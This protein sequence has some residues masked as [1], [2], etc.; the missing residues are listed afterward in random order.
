MQNAVNPELR[1]YLALEPSARGRE[2]VAL[3]SATLEY[4]L[5]LHL[6]G[7]G[8]S[9]LGRVSLCAGRA[10]APRVGGEGGSVGLRRAVLVH[11]LWGLQRTTAD[12]RGFSMQH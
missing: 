7:A 10:R 2:K 12:P 4:M 11:V 6:G 1:Y 8:G 3:W 5:E 9:P